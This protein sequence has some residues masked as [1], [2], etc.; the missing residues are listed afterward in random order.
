MYRIIV[1]VMVSAWIASGCVSAKKYETLENRYRSTDRRLAEMQ[2]TNVFNEETILDLRQ[3]V[4]ILVD[5]RTELSITKEKFAALQGSQEQIYIS[6]DNT[7]VDNAKYIST[8]SY[9]NT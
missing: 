6:Y 7:L 5:L 3:R 1:L 2:K 8:Y 4:Q 9:D